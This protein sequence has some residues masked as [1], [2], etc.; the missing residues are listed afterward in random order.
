MNWQ[1]KKVG[2]VVQKKRCPHCDRVKSA[3]H[4][5]TRK[6][7]RDGLSVWCLKCKSVGERIRI[8]SN[9]ERKRLLNQR[10]RARN[11]ARLNARDRDRYYK[12][13]DATRNNNLKNSYGITLHDYNA[14]LAAQGGSCACC[15][16][17]EA[18]GRS[19]HLHVDH[20]HKTGRIRALLCCKCNSILGFCRESPIHLRLLIS[21]IH[22]HELQ[23]PA[24]E[25]DNV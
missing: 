13:K 10:Y 14:M 8:M 22:E 3:V 20:C 19:Q 12:D 11:R 1:Q 6:T 25:P 18:G 2:R 24:M 4:F 17:D 23:Q 5:G 7:T 16:S 15:G 9:P 21:Y